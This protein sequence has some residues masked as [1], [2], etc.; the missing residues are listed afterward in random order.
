M[1]GILYSSSLLSRLIKQKHSFEK[2]AF[3]LEAAR[4]TGEEIIFFSLFDIDWKKGTV[5]SWNGTESAL[6]HRALPPVIINRT[7]TNHAHIKKWIQ[8]LKQMG[9]IIFNEH[10][11]VSKLDIHQIL[12]KNNK[13]LPHLPATESVTHDSVR[14]LLEQN[15]CLFLKPR[16]ASVGSGIIRIR[17]KED[18][19]VAGI[20]L[21]GR[22]KWQK[23]GIKQIIKIVRRTKRE[24]LVQQ[25]ISLMKY[26]GRSV[27]FRVSVQKDG[28]GR[29]HYTGMV[30]K[31][32]KKGA[33]VTNL[34]CGG[35]SLK[36]S[37][38]FHNWGWNGSIIERK[39]AKL[40]IRIAKTLDKE[41]PHIADLGLDIALDEQ[42]HPWLIE[43]NFRDLRITFQ[44]AGEKELWRATFA[45]PVYYA[46]FQNRQI[47]EQ[48]KRVLEKHVESMISATHLADE[49]P[50]ENKVV[51]E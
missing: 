8:R 44:D 48:E 22:T 18:K 25:G 11:V 34:H 17:K 1:I 2:P 36:A 42:Q 41:L 32:A 15:T 13:L 24:Y 9:K 39:V 37:E 27:D 31:V 49:L 6:L 50:D 21:L 47:K 16:S 33:I 3:Y 35:K 38:L 45:T 5:R 46:A 19:T 12:V 26:Q 29:W 14:D 4:K 10:N 40:A 20:N 30:G 7:R 28:K 51:N 23:V 43:V